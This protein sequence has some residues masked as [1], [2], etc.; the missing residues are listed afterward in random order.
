MGMSIVV[1]G[2]FSNYSRNELKELIQKH[3]GKNVSSISKKTNFVIEGKN[4]GPSKKEK[5]KARILTLIPL[6]MKV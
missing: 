3:G 2:I 4:M 6:I 5:A 1:S